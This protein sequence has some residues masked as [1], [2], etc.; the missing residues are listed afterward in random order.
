MNIYFF[1]MLYM[2]SKG[3]FSYSKNLYIVS[4][5]VVDV[6]ATRTLIGRVNKI[7]TLLQI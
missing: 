6:L 7:I 5:Y 3:T 2:T 1:K 4:S